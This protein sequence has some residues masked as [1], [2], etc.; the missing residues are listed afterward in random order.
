MRTGEKKEG[1][2]AS[3]LKL[4]E[5]LK[6]SNCYPARLLGMLPGRPLFD[7]FP[8]CRASSQPAP[9]DAAGEGGR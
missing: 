6:D 5:D 9:W 3:I 4:S 8:G 7:K 2:R 1:E